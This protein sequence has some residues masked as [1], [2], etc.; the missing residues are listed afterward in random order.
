MPQSCNGNLVPLQGLN[1]AI[2]E[3]IGVA[4]LLEYARRADEW[5]DTDDMVDTALYYRLIIVLHHYDI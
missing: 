5:P 1:C 2:D 3:W 4:N